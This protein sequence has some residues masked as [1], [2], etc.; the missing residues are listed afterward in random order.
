M[1]EILVIAL[2]LIN[3]C[4]TGPSIVSQWRNPAHTS[5]SF[6]RLL[7][8]GPPGETTLRRNFEDEFVA[9]LMTAGID[10]VPSYRYLP[11]NEPADENSL[12][13]AA[14]K[15]RADGL[16]LVRSAKV[17]EKTNYPVLGP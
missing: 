10:A 16:L 11:E 4:S 5:S 15:A 3:G 14:Q 7:V 12:K 2:A 1:G 8:G 13:Q 17:E 6:Q 9:Q